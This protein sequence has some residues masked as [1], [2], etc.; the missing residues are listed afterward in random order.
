[1]TSWATSPR[2]RRLGR[3][4]IRRQ[5][6]HSVATASNNVRF[7]VDIAPP[8]VSYDVS[9]LANGARQNGANIG[10]EFVAT[11]A[12]TGAVGNSGMLAGSPLIASVIRRE[13][14]GTSFTTAPQ[15][16]VVGTL[17]TSNTVCSQS[18]TGLAAPA[19]PLVSTAI[20][21]L[22]VDGYYTY[23]STALDAAGNSTP[24]AAARVIVYDNEPATATPPS[25]PA[26]ITG[27]FSSAS[28]LNDN[29]SIRDYYYTVAFNTAAAAYITPSTFR[30]AAAPTVVDAFN[31]ATLSNTNVGIN[32]SINTFLGL[33]STT[34][35]NVPNA[36]AAGSIPMN[37]LNLFVRD[38]AQAAYSGPFST[39]VAPTAPAAG[40]AI[41]NAAPAWTFNT[42]VPATSNATICANT[43]VGGC[44]ATPTSTV[45]TAVAS[46]TTAT[47]PNPFGRVDFFAPL[48]TDLILIG[49]VPAAS[50]T[51]VDNGATRVWTYS[52]T[53]QAATLYPQLGGVSPAVI[54]PIPIFAFGVNAAGNVALVAQGVAQTINP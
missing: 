25:V 52:L 4:A 39:V 15:D 24:I 16:C 13:A 46:G 42:F 22:T 27:A 31:A 36:Y 37:G 5:L 33:Q 21:A 54:G 17:I 35:G 19:L 8:T 41:T 26:T 53:L 11:L 29:L 3:L 38:Q 20:A 32:T 30:I 50:A 44:G 7:G 49:S 14:T 48:G 18:T 2:F 1:M 40:V 6:P 34:G 43:L 28:F 12:D 9:S 10:G 47:F 45:V 51:L 23:T